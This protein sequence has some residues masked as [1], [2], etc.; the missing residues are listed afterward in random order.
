MMISLCLIFFFLFLLKIHR[1]DP[2]L[3]FHN[4]KIGKKENPLSPDNTQNLWVPRLGL[5]NGLSEFQTIVTEDEAEIYRAY[6]WRRSQP[7]AN[8]LEMSV[9]GEKNEGKEDIHS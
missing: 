4:L 3:T 1:Y 6:V 9:E 8:G 5:L 2:R 7:D